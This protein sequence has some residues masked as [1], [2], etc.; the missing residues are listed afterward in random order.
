MLLKKNLKGENVEERPSR[1]LEE[2]KTSLKKI[3]EKEE[4]E[5]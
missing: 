1:P 5:W 4:F 3:L 2:K